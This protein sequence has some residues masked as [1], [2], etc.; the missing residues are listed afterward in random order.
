MAIP[1]PAPDGLLP[2]G[3]HD[4]SI[5]DIRTRFGAFQGSDRRPR[6]F[7]RLEQYLSE[8][9]RTR[10]LQAVIV[11]G[12]FVTAVAEPNDV[13]LV[14]VLQPGHDFSADLQPFEYNVLS[15]RQVQKHYG[16]DVLV[17]AAGSA[18]AAEYEAF[19]AQV[20]G[21]PGRSKGLLRLTLD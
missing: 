13:D 16:I 21:A 9:R 3:L 17:A 5:D 20:R 11:D 7:E 19:F 14:L 8:V 4:C 6:L 1:E 10:L 15:R 12:S 18:A 2:P